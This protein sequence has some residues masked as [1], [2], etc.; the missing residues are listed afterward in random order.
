MIDSLNRRR[1]VATDRLYTRVAAKPANY[2][3]A[4]SLAAAVALMLAARLWS[5]S[6]LAH[7]DAITIL[8]VTCNQGR[9]AASIPAQHW[10]S[11]ADWQSYWTLKSPGCF[12][13][14]QA[15]MAHEDIHPPLYFWLLHAWLMVFGVS[16]PAA[17]ALNFVIVALTAV[18]IVKTCRLLAVRAGSVCIVGLT[19]ALTMST[20]M[21]ATAV[22][23]YSLLGLFSALLLLLVVLWFNRNRLAYLVALVP[24][25]AG[26]L[27]TQYLF[28][29][30]AAMALLLVGI[31]LLRTHR[32]R[33]LAVVAT[34]YVVAAMLFVAANPEFAYSMHRGSQQAQSFSWAALPV[35]IVAVLAQLVEPFVPLDPAYQFDPVMIAVCGFTALIVLPM[36]VHVIRWALTLRHERRAVPVTS[37]SVPMLMFLGC[38]AAVV[39]FFVLFISPEHAMRPIYLYFLTPFLFVGLAVAAQRSARVVAS[40]TTLFVY[41]FV[42]VAVATSVFVLAQTPKPAP[43]I[44]SHSAIVLDS[45]RRGIVPTTLWSVP[46]DAITYAATQSD[47]LRQFPGLDAVGD[48]DLYYVSRIMPGAPYGNSTAKRKKILQAFTDRGYSPRFVGTSS[49]MGGAEVY[50][51]TRK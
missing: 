8:G 50:R 51:L 18:V 31:T 43:P 34:G 49:A 10:V 19:W 30:P 6:V 15:D 13:T 33:E 38:S 7:D 23:Q 44:G 21:A 47:L 40:V 46:P 29:I 4:L 3:I 32:Y 16:V 28:F 45:D 17:L 41:Q 48:R 5:A 25:V 24:V 27:L 35:R 39:A 36:V 26:G 14:I 11:A 37:E 42:G 20:R 12:G 1:A 2:W 22:R 9:Y